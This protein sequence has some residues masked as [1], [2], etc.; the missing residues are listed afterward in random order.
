MTPDE[1]QNPALAPEEWALIGRLLE[2]KQR[3]LLAEIRHTDHRAFRERLMD[4]LEIVDR[5]LVRVHGLG[6]DAE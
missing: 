6:K 1:V 4:E 5:L 2:T 3:A